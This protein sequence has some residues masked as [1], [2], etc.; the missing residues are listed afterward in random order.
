M[1]GHADAQPDIS[2]VGG[3]HID[4]TNDAYEFLEVGLGRFPSSI[5]PYT[6]RR[7]RRCS[8]H[9][10]CCPNPPIVRCDDPRRHRCQFMF[11]G[12]DDPGVRSAAGVQRRRRDYV[13]VLPLDV[14]SGTKFAVA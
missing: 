4:S 3:N 10:G 6:S 12:M 5:P 11:V 2:P 7:S 8:W 13:G 14:E 9:I 1:Q